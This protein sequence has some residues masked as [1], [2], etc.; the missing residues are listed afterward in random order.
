MCASSPS[1]AIQFGC[2]HP[3][4]R[5]DEKDELD[6]GEPH[7]P[8]D[9][10]PAA[11]QRIDRLKNLVIHGATLATARLELAERVSAPRQVLETLTGNNTLVQVLDGAGNV[12]QSGGHGSGRPRLFGGAGHRRDRPVPD[13]PLQDEAERLGTLVADLLLLAR[14][15]E[16]GQRGHHRSENGGGVND[17][18]PAG[19]CPADRAATAWASVAN[20][21]S[22]R[23]VVI[24]VCARGRAALPGRGRRC[25]AASR[26][27][28][29]RRCPWPA[30]R[31]RS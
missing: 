20:R 5:E 25:R 7:D 9:R 15:D 31:R 3:S 22:G 18:G 1:P 21:G 29:G 13:H 6:R 27:C 12:A 16:H 17:A 4:D 2:D 19:E 30:W 26:R 8:V 14:S 24:R 23:P 11:G 10:R 28:V